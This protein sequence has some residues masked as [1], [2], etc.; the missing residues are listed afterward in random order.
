MDADLVQM[1]PEIV[2]VFDGVPDHPCSK[3]YVEAIQ[4]AL[5]ELFLEGGE[6]EELPILHQRAGEHHVA[7]TV[8]APY[9]MGGAKFVYE[10]ISRWLLPGQSVAI[11]SFFSVDF[12]MSNEL[13]TFC[14]LVVPVYEQEDL[15]LIQRHFPVL[16]AELKVGLVSVYHASRILET[17]GL[18]TDEKTVL[19]QERITRWLKRWPQAL[20][21]DVFVQMQHFLVTS[22]DEFKRSHEYRHMSRMICIFY[23]FKK[24]LQKRAALSPDK[25]HVLVK[26]VPAQLALPFGMRRVLGVLIGMT[27]F[28]DNEIFEKKHLLQLLKGHFPS[29]EEVPDSDFS[30]QM[31]EER[32]QL[33][34][35]EIGK[36]DGSEFTLAELQGVKE[37]IAE[38]APGSVERLTSPLFMPRNEEE[39]MRNI[40]TLAQQLKYPRDLPQAILSFDGQAEGKLC[41]TVVLLRVLFPQMPSVEELV[42][43]SRTFL[44]Y[45]SDRIRRVGL[46]RKK[47]PKEAT[48]FRVRLR[49]EP[50]FRS[51]HTVDLLKARQTVVTE[52][53]R[54]VGE[55]RDYNGGML[56]KQ[57]EQMNVL[58]R[59]LNLS[60]REELL[61]E[62]FFHSIFPVELRSVLPPRMLKKMFSMLLSQVATY[63]P[64]IEEDED[65]V[66]VL[67]SY[68]DL[69][70]KELV[71][72]EV[73]HLQFSSSQLATI[74][75]CIGEVFYLGFILQGDGGGKKESFLK[76]VKSRLE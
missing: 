2:T 20:D 65:G 52:L 13:F 9:R 32:I 30:F 14:D 27:F 7:L 59:M 5:I 73:S 35:V 67:V 37:G 18:S 12:Q 57:Q 4:A 26:L 11:S 72:E 54:I 31:K 56:A 39:V 1:L 45:R 22:H 29:A 76:I 36:A 15:E 48:V 33:L 75:L 28:G 6:L 16:E 69:S 34:Y 71:M 70:V 61:L 74:S 23:L 46:L 64:Y 49:A 17:K 66:Y 53:Q 19:I 68:Q 42:R 3:I 24:A 21:S 50:F 41:F 25:R 63:P 58:K 44:E 47:Y 43:R 60:H 10:M 40:I 38:E 55:V 51:D 8:L 62:N